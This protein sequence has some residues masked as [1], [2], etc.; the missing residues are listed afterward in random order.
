MQANTSPDERRSFIL[1]SLR[2]NG[3]LTTTDL[4]SKFDISEDSARRDFRELAAEGLIQRVHGAALQ[5][6]SASQ[7]FVS[8]YK[9]SAGTKARLAR[10]A[11]EH[12]EED[13]VVLFDGGTT[14][15][16]IATQIPKTLP[17][18]AITNSPQIA[19]ALSEHRS[20]ETILLGGVFDTR[21]QMTVGSAVLDAVQ[22]VRA[23]ICFTGVHGIDAEV[24]LTTPYYDEALTKAAMVAAGIKVI[25]VATKDKVGFRAAHTIC[26]IASLD[27]LI[28]E[29]HDDLA[30]QLSAIRRSKVIVEHG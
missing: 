11:A 12:V 5:V 26:G 8:R 20:V 22:R 17:F 10:L 18:S 28:A 30:P 23:D 24:G 19:N 27:L 16:A 3:R 9:I 14:N 29:N 13:Q 1:K 6:S 21:S 2:E 15:L 4:A 25:A 7:P